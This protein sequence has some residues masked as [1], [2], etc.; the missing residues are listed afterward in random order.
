MNEVGGISDCLQDHV[1]GLVADGG[2]GVHVEVV[3]E[4]VGLVVNGVCRWS[5][6]F[7]SDFVEGDVDAGI[8]GSS[9]VQEATIDESNS[10][11]AV[12]VKGLSCEAQSCV[13]CQSRIGRLSQTVVV[14]LH[15]LS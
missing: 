9:I 5:C 7:G 4:H 15:S 13:L 2:V 8:D 3:H 10:D 1:A 11:S 6:L 14:M 12:S